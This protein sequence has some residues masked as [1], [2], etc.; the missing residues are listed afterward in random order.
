MASQSLK[1][2][3]PRLDA[4]EE[5]ARGQ[6]RSH[7]VE[8]YDP[9]RNPDDR[10]REERF[11]NLNLTADQQDQALQH[12]AVKVRECREAAAHLVPGTE[13][14]ITPALWVLVLTATL[15]LAGT[16]IPTI[17]DALS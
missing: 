8:P 12:S 5:A 2:V 14:L 3:Q 1:A 13:P 6:L 10:A 17:I 16:L 15:A 4:L 9:A 7:N 11:A